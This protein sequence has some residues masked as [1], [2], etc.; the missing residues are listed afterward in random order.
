VSEQDRR[1]GL[2]A[3]ADAVAALLETPTENL[4]ERQADLQSAAREAGLTSEEISEILN[5]RADLPRELLPIERDT[6]LAILGHADFVGRDELVAQVDS[7]LVVGYCGC[8]CAT[9]NLQVGSGAP[10]APLTPSPISTR[11]T[12][13]DAAGEAIGGIVIFLDNEGYLGSLEIYG[14]LESHGIS[15]L[16]PVN[17]LEF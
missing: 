4:L 5:A 2:K 7:T 10:P 6:L 11:P 15:P 13:L 17:R 12:V 1:E 8:G 9:I 3:K 14:W 16:P